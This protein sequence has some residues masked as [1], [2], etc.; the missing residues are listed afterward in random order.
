MLG[1]S[2]PVTMNADPLHVLNTNIDRFNELMFK[3]S[4]RHDNFK[5]FDNLNFSLAHLSRDGLHFNLSGQRVT[6][7]CWVH[8]VLV[9]LGL[10]RGSLPIHQNFVKIYNDF[11]PSP[12]GS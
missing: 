8:V 11:Q 12:F 4:L 3:C 6:S 10:R 2:F 9:R 1:R 5:L 7:E